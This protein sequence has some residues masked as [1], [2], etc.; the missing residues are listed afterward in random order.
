M[1]FIIFAT[2]GDLMPLRRIPL[3]G[4]LNT[5]DLGGYPAGKKQ[6]TQF[7]RI[8]R[9]DAPL[10]LNQKDIAQLKNLGV[11]AAI[12]FR[13]EDEITRKPSAFEKSAEFAYFHCPFAIG[14]Q[15]PGSADGVPPLYAKIISDFPIMRQVMKIIT[16]QRGAVLI[17]CAAGKDRTGVVSALLLLTAGVAVSDILVDYQISFTYRRSIFYEMRKQNPSLPYYIGRTDMAYMEKT[18]DVF[19]KT[20]DTI[21]DY[22][23]RI[24]LTDE[25]TEQLN[26]KLLS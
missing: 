20:Y 10:I 22:L 1:A 24:G 18:L 16:R 11:T 13:S 9:S 15:D 19:F 5:R 3:S 6:V 23:T 26:A 4:T 7:G 8:I 12:D 21:Q 14:N 25:E 17:H 2:G